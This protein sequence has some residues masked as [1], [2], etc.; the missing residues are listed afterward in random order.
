MRKLFAILVV[1]VMALS[2]L[3]MTMSAA[4]ADIVHQSVEGTAV[5]D[6]VKDDAYAN[7][8]VLAL[9]EKGESNNGGP[10]LTGPAAHAYYINDAEFVYVFVEVYDSEL[11][12]TS[13]N[14]YERDSVEAFWMVDNAKT[15]VRYHYD[16]TVDNDSGESVE[17]AAV[18]TDNGYAV[19]FKMPITDVKDNCIETCVQINAAT[20][21]ARDCT[22]YIAGNKA[23]DNA[24]QRSN[25]QSDYDV[26]WTLALAGD[27]ADSRVD[28]VEE[29]IE[30]TA[31]NYQNMYAVSVYA[32]LY[33]QGKVDWSEWKSMSTGSSL[34]LGGSVTPEGWQG[35][36]PHDVFSEAAVD[37]DGN[38]VDVDAKK[39]SNFTVDPVW[40]MQIGDDNFLAPSLTGKDVGA[41]GDSGRYQFTYTDITIKATGYNDVVVPGATITPKWLIKQENGYTSGAATTIDLVIPAKEQLGLTTEQLVKE[42]IPAV[43]D[44]LT[45]ITFDKFE[46]L[47]L[48]DVKAFEETLV[49]LEQAFIDTELADDT[50]KVNAA[51]EAAKAEGATADDIAKALSDATKAVNHAKKLCENNNYSG[52][53]LEHCEK[54]LGD[55]VAEIQALADAAATPAEDEAPAEDAKD[56]KPA[57]ADTPAEEKSGN[58]GMVVG[59]IVVVAVIVVAAVGIVLGKKKK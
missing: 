56:E 22:I 43:T 2:L 8:L 3:P 1:A 21:G 57:A 17:S 36:A 4:T 29:P 53:A 15:Q 23:A 44:V 35:M 37:E 40:S 49:E 54:T 14:N 13:T 5:I 59:I 34:K 55:A 18:I 11:D 16:G 51:L 31:K 10:D 52:I 45:T 47:T 46:L 26:W 20:A 28:P 39:T 58:T 33:T 7:A 32:Q 30:L 41:T 38:E 25:R 48:D 42:Y 12:N 6:G 50:A 27:H 9:E 19:E 24:Y